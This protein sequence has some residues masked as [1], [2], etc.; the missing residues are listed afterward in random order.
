MRVA[1]C[2]VSDTPQELPPARL[3]ANF[4]FQPRMGR[5]A[6]RPSQRLRSQPGL[7]YPRVVAKTITPAADVTALLPRGDP[8]VSPRGGWSLRCF[9]RVP[10][11]RPPPHLAG[12]AAPP[13]PDA[14]I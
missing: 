5:A 1:C 7:W 10:P 9:G 8:P 11:G 6:Q 13:P 4:R 2:S 3:S 12:G 14:F